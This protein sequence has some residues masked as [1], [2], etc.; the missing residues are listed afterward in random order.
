MAWLRAGSQSRLTAAFLAHKKSTI[1]TLVLMHIQSMP[2]KHCLCRMQV[3]RD[4]HRLKL[5]PRGEPL[6]ALLTRDLKHQNLMRTMSHAWWVASDRGGL[7]GE[8]QCWMILEYCNKGSVVVSRPDLCR[9]LP[10]VTVAPFV[11]VLHVDAE[12]S[13]NSSS[14]NSG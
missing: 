5:D 2:S 13:N 12:A 4:I 14:K 7:S 1:H 3:V 6:E 10:P 9:T 8:Q 11:A